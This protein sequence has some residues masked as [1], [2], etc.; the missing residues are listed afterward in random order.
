[1]PIK[2]LPIAE[3]W[4][5]AGCARCCR[6]SL[7]WLEA[8]DLQKLS[9]QK[10][11]EHPEYRGRPVV[12]REGWLS[13]RMR[14]AQREDGRCVFLQDDGRCRIHVEFGADAKPLACRMFPL[15]LV[16]HERHAVLTLRRSC[17][18]AAADQGPPISDYAKSVGNLVREGGLLDGP[19]QPPPLTRSRRGSWLELQAVA[20]SLDRLVADTRFPL[21]RRLAH[22]L[23]FCDLLDECRLSRLDTGRLRDLCRVLEEPA[24]Q[25]GELFA[26]RAAPSASARV[27]FRQTAAEYLR[28]HPGFVVRSGL[29]ARWRLGRMAIGMARGRGSV[30]RDNWDFPETTFEALERPLGHLSEA[31]QRPWLR[32]YTAQTGSYQYAVA[33]RPGWPIVDS[34]RALALAYPVSLW[35]LRWIT[36]DEP[37]EPSHVIDLISMIDRGQGFAPLNART[38]RVRVQTLTRL[39]ELT[40]LLAW[41]AR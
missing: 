23:R 6:G 36:T 31:L 3:Q 27:L 20:G 13:G 33:S 30:P 32:F 29:R 19:F 10:W 12:L 37:P 8:D 17:P 7:I 18:T 41:Y 28:V 40:R 4:Q 1:M 2:T 24:M 14:L 21:V 35:V 25:V 34:F 39:G 11:D 22:A 15:Q 38:F 5:C 16:P 9:Q 26:E